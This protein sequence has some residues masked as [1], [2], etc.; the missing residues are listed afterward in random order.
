MFIYVDIKKRL[1]FR[2]CFTRVARI[3]QK[4]YVTLIIFSFDR[5]KYNSRKSQQRYLLETLTPSLEFGIDCICLIVEL[6]LGNEWKGA[7]IKITSHI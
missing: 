7:L 4:K 3:L 1:N 2:W 5:S 6:N